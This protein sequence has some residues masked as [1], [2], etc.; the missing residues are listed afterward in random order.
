M[1]SLSIYIYNMNVMYNGFKT[2]KQMGK[3]KR[4]KAL[5]VAGTLRKKDRGLPPDLQPEALLRLHR[6]EVG[7]E[8]WASG[9]FC[10]LD[11]QGELLGQ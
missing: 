1:L 7:G 4:E 5:T 10:F 3:Q 6:R 9:A 8:F 2:A 11:L